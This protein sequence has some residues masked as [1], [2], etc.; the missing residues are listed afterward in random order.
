MNRQDADNAATGARSDDVADP[1]PICH[2]AFHIGDGVVNLPCNHR[3]HEPCLQQWLGITGTCPLCRKTIADLTTADNRL[4]P[5]VSLAEVFGAL[6]GGP[7]MVTDSPPVT[8]PSIRTGNIPT[9]M[10][11]TSM[12]STS[13]GGP[14]AQLGDLFGLL[15]PAFDAMRQTPPSQPSQVDAVAQILQGLG[16][17]EPNARPHANPTT[18]N[19]SQRR[20]LDSPDMTGIVM[21]DVD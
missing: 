13:I 12:P 10:A 7:Q 6:S 11:D 19:S 17:D 18:D 1:C 5:D 9:D 20:S 16:L 14:F 2:D 15:S 4:A 21:E 8:G 3:Y